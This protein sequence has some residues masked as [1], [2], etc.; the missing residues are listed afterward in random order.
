MSSTLTIELPDHIV[1]LLSDLASKTNK[2]PETL[3]AVSITGNLPPA[4]PRVPD[5]WQAE[6]VTM[7][8]LSKEQLRIIADSQL[9]PTHQQRHLELL[10]K[11]AEATISPQEGL[12]LAQ[13]RETADRHMLKKAYAWA[14]LRWRGHPVPSL[15]ELPLE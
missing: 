7:Q 8:D 1:R 13:L 14:L 2:S 12:E 11:N 6:F 5:A 9:P 10:E 4:I 3:A 15:D